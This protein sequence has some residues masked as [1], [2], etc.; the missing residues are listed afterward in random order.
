MTVKNITITSP[1]TNQFIL[2][3]QTGLFLVAGPC[4]IENQDICCRIAETIKTIADKL[5]IPYVFKASFDKANRTSFD[6]FRGPG[7]QEGLKILQHIR[8]QFQI[9]VVSDIHT[10]E[11]A[12]PAAQVLD[13]I[14]LPAFLIRQTDLIEAAA[15]TQK[16]VQLK[17]A[18]FMA[19]WDMKNVVAKANACD[20]HNLTL[21]ERGSSFGYNRLVC[22]M[23][24]IPQMQT[25]GYPTIIDATH[26]TQQP[27]G[28]GNASGG[29]PDMAHVLARS[30]VAAGADGIF[31]ETHPDPANALSDAAC[32]I[33]LNQIENL[34][35]TCKNIYQSIRNQ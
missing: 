21:V 12:A 14:Q 29:A 1:T 4:V 16:C 24:A 33:P 32:M 7:L 27:G 10:P 22:D 8:E 2:G 9:P 25:L 23:T 28:L 15:R 11:Q 20:N 31:I 34:L 35:K 3:P 26:S 5:Q 19:P 17:K 18:Q 6:S 13:I 30:A